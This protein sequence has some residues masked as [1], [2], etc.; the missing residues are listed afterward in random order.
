MIAPWLLLV[1]LSGPQQPL[2]FR[3]TNEDLCKVALN[4][5]EHDL[6]PVVISGNCLLIGDSNVR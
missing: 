1:V 4:K 6:G 3:I 2:A 5:L